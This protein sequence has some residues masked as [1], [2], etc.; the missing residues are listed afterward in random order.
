MAG[1]RFLVCAFDGTLATRPSTWAAALR[2][3]SAFLLQ[4]RCPPRR[5]FKGEDTCY[6]LPGAIQQPFPGTALRAAAEPG[7]WDMNG[8]K[9]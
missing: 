9:V 5:A 8:R 3:E 6:S 2:I 7:G 4:E 1:G